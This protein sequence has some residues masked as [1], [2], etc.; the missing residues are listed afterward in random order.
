LETLSI[1]ICTPG[2]NEYQWIS[3]PTGRSVA[4]QAERDL[5]SKGLPSP[6]AITGPPPEKMIVNFETCITASAT[7]TPVRI[8]F[9]TGTIST[10]D[11]AVVSCDPWGSI[12]Y[13]ACTW[14]PQ[15]PSIEAATGTTDLTYH[16]SVSIIWNVAW[17]SSTGE[18][19]TLDPM[20]TTTPL[21][22]TVMEIQTIGGG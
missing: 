19:G 11:V 17:T 2:G 15:F 14:T 18:R 1:R 4:G 22:I 12:E 7:A 16:G 10:K 21:N 20:T 3:S 6:V 9:N 13:G 5:Q 8:E